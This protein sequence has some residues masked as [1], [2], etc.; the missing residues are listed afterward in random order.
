MSTISSY[1][2]GAVATLFSSLDST[3]TSN[4]SSWAGISDSTGLSGLDL[5]TYSSI[6]SGSYKK[7]L[8][9]Y[10]ANQ[11]SANA[12]PSDSSSGNDVSVSTQKL[13]ATKVRDASA[14]VKDSS[15]VLNKASLW[16][17]AATGSQ[18]TATYNTSAIYK[19]VTSFVTDYNSLVSGAAGSSDHSILR[20]AANM[21]SNT[22]AN[23]KLLAEIGIT[24]GSDNKLSIDESSFKSAD[25]AAVKSVFYGAGSFW[26]CCIT[27]CKAGNSRYVFE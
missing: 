24:I 11:E 1:N 4:T 12:A 14:Q 23:K 6:Q 8:A 13:N 5:S 20:T 15:A 3:N 7:L 16:A 27:A 10:Y 2:A 18:G 21:V 25:M 22:S 17:K 26:F 19:A 9:K